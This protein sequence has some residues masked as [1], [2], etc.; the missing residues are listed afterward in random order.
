M[1]A[2]PADVP[3]KPSSL[4]RHA[5]ELV[6]TG[7]L[8]ALPLFALFAAYA[9]LSPATYETAAKLTLTPVA[10]QSSSAPPLALIRELQDAALDQQTLE[11]LASERANEDPASRDESAH[12]TRKAFAIDTTDGRNFSVSFQDSDPKRTQAVC[13]LLAS[14]AL[15]QA[16]RPVH[17]EAAQPSPRARLTAEL[18]AFL[19]KHPNVALTKAPAGSPE[20]DPVVKAL[21]TERLQLENALLRLGKPPASDN[22]YVKLPLPNREHLNARLS[23]VNAALA[24]RRNLSAPSG[25]EKAQLD[26]AAEAEWLRLMR[27]I[28][29]APDDAA[30][31]EAK[32]RFTAHLQAAPLPQSPVRPDR[33]R[34]LLIGALV[35]L[36]AGLVAMVGRAKVA[37]SR[38]S[39]ATRSRRASQSAGVPTPQQ[40][41]AANQLPIVSTFPGM[42]PAAAAPPSPIPDAPD[43]PA[44]GTMP[45]VLPLPGLFGDLRGRV[46]QAEGARPE[47]ASTLPIA[48]DPRAAFTIADATPA[49]APRASPK[50]TQILGSP[51]SVSWHKA[52]RG[53][54]EGAG[55]GLPNTSYSYVNATAEVVGVPP[56]ARHDRSASSP[57]RSAPPR[58]REPEMPPAAHVPEHSQRPGAAPAK[59]VFVERPVYG[60]APNPALDAGRY[61][62]FGATLLQHRGACLVLCVTGPALE[63]KARVATE[64]AMAVA[65]QR[66]VLLV[67]ADF[68]LP[69]VHESLALEM[70]L[71][72]GYSHQ[73]R[74]RVQGAL[75]EEPWR[76]VEV[77]PSFHVLAEGVLRSPGMILSR[78][79]EDSISDLR[80]QYDFLVVHG[81]SLA[82]EVDLRALL[83]VSD[84]VLLAGLR[85]GAKV[86]D[87]VRDKHLLGSVER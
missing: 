54:A 41:T 83:A 69:A 43:G 23:A 56:N 65:Q 10:G 2:A 32:P 27:A 12:R 81:P 57:P 62:E 39:R 29:Q 73:L 31:A 64:L 21:L 33:P 61:K 37:P 28:Q 78:E 74:A 15:L 9:F 34:V 25:P 6:P 19:E 51:P 4:G 18:L 7:L 55:S 87:I 66:R 47:A 80:T 86:P 68:Q 67:D 5:G 17:S 72:A 50:V 58:A 8:V 77:R 84:G 45:L 13:N 70:S 59:L 76:V 63:F 46:N 20:A 52:V 44:S 60:W 36:A 82:S 42:A 85:K 53:A 75:R 48:T 49:E 26:G 3:A 11:R 35:G 14:R 38:R 30:P 40:P 1:G 24:K 22:P 79:F 16:T 71:S